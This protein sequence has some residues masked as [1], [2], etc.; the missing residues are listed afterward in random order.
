MRSYAIR[1][2]IPC[3]AMSCEAMSC[4]LAMPIAF[5]AQL[6]RKVVRAVRT[7]LEHGL[8]FLVKS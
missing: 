6:E 4:E 7:R 1:E 8:V 3:E 2:A 5:C